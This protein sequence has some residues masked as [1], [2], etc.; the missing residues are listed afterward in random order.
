MGPEILRDL[1]FLAAAV[2]GAAIFRAGMQFGTERARTEDAR[3]KEKVLQQL[4]H[5]R[6]RREML[7]GLEPVFLAPIRPEEQQEELRRSH[8]GRGDD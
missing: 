7:R 1:L 3:E 5:L 2:T 8:A 6:T 4:Q